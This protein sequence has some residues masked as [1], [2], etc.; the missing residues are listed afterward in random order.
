MQTETSRLTSGTET[1]KAS[2]L[3]IGDVIVTPGGTKRPVARVAISG[4]NEVSVNYS[5]IDS[6]L[7]TFH[8]AWELV[9]VQRHMAQPLT[10]TIKASDLRDGDTIVNPTTG[11][12]IPVLLATR[13]LNP[14]A[15]VMIWTDATNAFVMS[16]SVTVQIAARG[17]DEDDNRDFAVAA[18]AGA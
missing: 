13:A 8:P 15:L 16:P 14:G 5:G 2:Q 9:I 4:T 7:T 11:E 18:K 1:I 6:G 17:G 10:A 3:A 12:T